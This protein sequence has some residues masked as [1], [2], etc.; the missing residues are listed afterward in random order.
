MRSPDC[1]YGHLVDVLLRSNA[2]SGAVVIRANFTDNP[3]FPEVLR[4][5]LERD[6]ADPEKFAH[7]W[8]GS[9]PINLD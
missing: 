5:D 6:R 1:G 2:P 4:S 7:I 8:L 9:G 3:F